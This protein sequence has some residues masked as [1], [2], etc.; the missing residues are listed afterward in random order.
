MKF[1]FVSAS[2]RQSRVTRA[3][4]APRG[5]FVCVPVLVPVSARRQTWRSSLFWSV[6][7]HLEHLECG[8]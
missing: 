8:H 2:A 5:I 3:Q 1:F 7:Q 6:V 4:L